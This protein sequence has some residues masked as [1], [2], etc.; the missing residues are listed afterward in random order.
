MKELVAAINR[1][2]TALEQLANPPADPGDNPCPRCLG[3]RE[4]APGVLCTDCN[5]RGH[6]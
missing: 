2:A 1:L 3:K 4:F 5:G 6:L